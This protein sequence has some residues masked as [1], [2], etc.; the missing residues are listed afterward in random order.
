MLD[1]FREPDMP[2][3]W[4]AL[5]PHVKG[6]KNSFIVLQKFWDYENSYAARIQKR[7]AEPAPL[8]ELVEERKPIR[9]K[10]RM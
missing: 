2:I 5:S 1:R 4:I 7:F 6:F 3:T 8:V 9:P 10:L